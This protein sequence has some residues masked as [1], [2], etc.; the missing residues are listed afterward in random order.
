MHVVVVAVR[1]MLALAYSG[2]LLER[3]WNVLGTCLEYVWNVLC[4]VRI[5]SLATQEFSEPF[6]DWPGLDTLYAPSDR[7]ANLATYRHSDTGDR[8]DSKTDVI[9]Q[10]RPYLFLVKPVY[11]ID[12]TL[13]SQDPPLLVDG[14]ISLQSEPFCKPEPWFF[15]GDKRPDWGT[16][17]PEYAQ[18]CL[19]QRQGTCQ[20]GHCKYIRF[21]APPQL[22]WSP[23]KGK[24]D[25]YKFLLHNDSS[26]SIEAW[27]KGTNNWGRTH[28]CTYPYS[29]ALACLADALSAPCRRPVDAS[30]L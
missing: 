24:E 9:H 26:E 18:T 27:R 19:Q 7:S 11:R 5:K 4:A 21:G 28:Q 10:G 16:L 29:A 25:I 22:A 20:T 23:T 17:P 12:P 14:Q 2:L 13:D 30:H 6:W 15:L 1:A 8:G 3:A